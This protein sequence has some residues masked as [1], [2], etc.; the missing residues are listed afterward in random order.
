MRLRTEFQ[1]LPRLYLNA[2]I[3]AFYLEITGFR[4]SMLDVF[5]GLEY[6]PWKHL[7]VGL[8][9]NFTGMQIDSECRAYI[10]PKAQIVEEG[11]ESPPGDPH[12]GGIR[13]LHSGQSGLETG[14]V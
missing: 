12:G 8:G 9:Y 6:R 5:A 14:R 10:N 1:L 13:G 3:D 11:K 4:G 7:G 2:G